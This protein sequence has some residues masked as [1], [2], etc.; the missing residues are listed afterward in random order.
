MWSTA[1]YRD[2]S[3]S[4]HIA[5]GRMLLYQLSLEENVE[6]RYKLF[7]IRIFCDA[8]TFKGFTFLFHTGFVKPMCLHL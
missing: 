6:I 7:S 4:V 2:V 8:A 5:V 3:V 1:V